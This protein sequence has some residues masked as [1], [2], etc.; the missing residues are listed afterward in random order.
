MNEQNV[1]KELLQWHQA[2][3]AGLQIELE[4]ESDKLVFENE[5]HY[6]FAPKDLD[7]N[8]LLSRM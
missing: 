2:F 6:S 8:S 5:H 1:D 7:L 4:A 3:Y